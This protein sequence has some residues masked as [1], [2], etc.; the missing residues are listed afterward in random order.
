M[1]DA[2]EL[3]IANLSPDGFEELDRAKILEPTGVAQGRKVVWAHPA[4]SNGKMFTRNDKEVVCVSLKQ[5]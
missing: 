1:D 3:I 5:K 4:F 2:G